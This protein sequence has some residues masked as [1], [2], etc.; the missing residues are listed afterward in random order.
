MK[1]GLKQ[2][3][4]ASL[5]SILVVLVV[6][7]GIF[8]VAFKLYPAYWDFHLVDS[9]LTDITQTPS[10]T[11]KSTRELKRDLSKKFLINQIKLPEDDSLIL[12][13]EK[14]RLL[15]KLN[16][17]VRVPMFFNVDA[18]V[19]FDKQYEANTP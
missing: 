3:Q 9:V 4:G 14:D 8:S 10:E 16:Y 15:I 18:M 7:G 19:R 6:A 5:L 17:E 12:E 2:Q 11:Q 1:A 13:K